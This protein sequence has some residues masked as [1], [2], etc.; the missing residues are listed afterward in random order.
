MERRI[1]GGEAIEVGRV[2]EGIGMEEGG[3]YYLVTIR[4]TDRLKKQTIIPSNNGNIIAFLTN[5]DVGDNKKKGKGN[6]RGKEMGNCQR[7]WEGE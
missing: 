5:P 6:K 3:V 7:E 1:G 4:Q 2:E